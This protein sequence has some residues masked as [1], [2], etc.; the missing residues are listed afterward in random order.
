[1][2]D[3]LHCHTAVTYQCVCVFAAHVHAQSLQRRRTMQA[4]GVSTTTATHMHIKTPPASYKKHHITNLALLAASSTACTP[5]VISRQS[6]TRNLRTH[7]THARTHAITHGSARLAA[8]AHKATTADRIASC[9][10]G[11][12][13]SALETHALTRTHDREGDVHSTCSTNAF[14]SSSR[15]VCIHSHATNITSHAHDPFHD[16]PQQR[17]RQPAHRAHIAPAQRRR[18]SRRLPST[19]SAATRCCLTAAGVKAPACN[20][21]WHVWHTHMLAHIHTPQCTRTRRQSSQTQRT[22]WN[23]APAARAVR[24]QRRAHA[25][26]HSSSL[27]TALSSNAL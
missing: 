22:C 2:C 20:I 18:A 13:G 10:H 19:Q 5:C 1:M 8:A 26:C 3:R 24:A 9:A 25:L 16:V 7:V 23:L 12:G 15:C 27:Q 4:G 11:H 17:S 6:S 21:S 14:V